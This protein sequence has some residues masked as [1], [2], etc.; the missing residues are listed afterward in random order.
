MFKSVSF[1]HDFPYNNVKDLLP[2]NPFTLHLNYKFPLF[3][4]FHLSRTKILTK[5]LYMDSRKSQNDIIPQC[6]FNTNSV[7]FKYI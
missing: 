6:V 2:Q 4:T 7:N 5:F 1:S 3:F